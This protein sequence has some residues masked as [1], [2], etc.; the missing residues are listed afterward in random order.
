MA[1]RVVPG[2]VGH[3]GRGILMGLA[4][5]FPSVSAGTIALILGVHARLVQAIA[6]IDARIP[7]DLVGSLRGD[8]DARHNLGRLDLWFLIPLVLGMATA[9][10]GG[11]AI[12]DRLLA[13]APQAMMALFVGL[14][15]AGSRVP[16]TRIPHVTPASWLWGALGA[17]L[18]ASTAF[19]PPLVAIQGGFGYVL[20]G[21]IA[22]SFMLLPGVSGSSMMVVLGIYEPLIGAARS[23]AIGPLLLFAT[24]GLGGLLVC[25]RFLQWLLRRHPGPT[26]AVLAGLILGSLVRVWPWRTEN[27]FATG[28]PAA[29][30]WDLS[31]V[32]LLCAAGLGVL[33]VAGLDRIGVPH[34]A[35][36]DRPSAPDTNE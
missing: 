3:Y 18:A 19:L 9:I 29:P 33:L 16:W 24:G 22:W 30:V 28:L 12:V 17:A 35:G 8:A 4:G 10:F 14:M 31:L 7:R 13:A 11:V 6:S 27:G 21:F 34:D 1:S 25:S 36:D 5:L 2:P 20:A 23:F 32:G 26:F 15:L